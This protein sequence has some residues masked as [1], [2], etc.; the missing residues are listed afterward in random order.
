MKTWDE[1]RRVLIQIDVKYEMLGEKWKPG[2]NLGDAYL[3]NANLKDAY[4]GGANLEDANLRNADLEDANLAYANL[5]SA[6]LEGANLKDAHLNGANLNGA[7]LGNAYGIVTIQFANL[8]MYIQAKNTIIG[9]ESRTNEEWL[10]IDIDTAVG[11]GIEK[12]YFEAYHAF[13]KAAML[14]LQ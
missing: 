3:E 13:F 4:L 6:N 5:K 1:T 2:I 12:E 9:R 8:S 10:A 11:L 7:Y 14:I